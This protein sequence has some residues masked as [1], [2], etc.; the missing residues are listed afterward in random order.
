[1]NT[2]LITRAAM[3]GTAVVVAAAAA[4]ATGT[5][6]RTPASAASQHQVVTMSGYE[7]DT[8]LSAMTKYTGNAEVVVADVTAVEPARWNTPSGTAPDAPDPLSFIFTPVRVSVVDVLRGDGALAGQELTVRRF[9]GTVGGVTFQQEH[10]PVAALH[11]GQRVVLFLQPEQP[12]DDGR[13][14]RIPNAAYVLQADGSLL[15]PEGDASET[16][17]QLKALLGVA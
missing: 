8:R 4:G 11:D 13:S 5:G 2:R 7:L 10:G 6:G 15:S 17:A 12:L 1:M 3:A 9:E 16:L 14:D